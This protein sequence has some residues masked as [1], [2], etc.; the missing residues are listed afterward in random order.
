[1]LGKYEERN[2]L[3]F[4]S[5]GRM[6]NTAPSYKK[7][8]W[9]ILRASLT[10]D[11]RYDYSLVGTPCARKKISII[12]PKHGVF[13]QYIGN[14]LAGNGCPQC[15]RKDTSDVLY[16]WKIQ[17]QEYIKIGITTSQ[18]K[19]H[20]INTV[21]AKWGVV[22]EILVYKV[23]S[24]ALH[25]ER[26]LKGLLKEHNRPNAFSGD[27]HTEVYEYNKQVMNLVGGYYD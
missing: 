16:I 18:L 9:F 27:G 12:C 19:N 17:G 11:W 13:S 8:E 26:V 10:H 6:K 20:R 14:H 1:M 25:R 4:S 21:A 24:N 15:K 22:P 2:A 3:Y 5:P 7:L 23:C